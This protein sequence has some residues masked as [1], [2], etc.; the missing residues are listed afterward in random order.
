M[1]FFNAML[2][3]LFLGVSNLALADDDTGPATDVRAAGERTWQIFLS[4]G[5]TIEFKGGWNNSDAARFRQE[6]F[7]YI[8]N[9]KL[10]QRPQYNFKKD[11]TSKQTSAVLFIKMS[12]VVSIAQKFD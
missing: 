1:R 8:N 7:D 6:F 4:S 12:E 9:G 5:E 2:V 3:L 10:P 11:N